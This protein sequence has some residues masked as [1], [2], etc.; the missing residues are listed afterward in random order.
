MMLIAMNRCCPKA[1]P[2]GGEVCRECEEASRAYQAA[3]G[4]N[5]NQ[6]TAA[7]RPLANLPERQK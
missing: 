3:M 6:K 2:Q 7:S 1:I 5:T 4:S